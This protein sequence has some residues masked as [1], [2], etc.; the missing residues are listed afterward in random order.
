MEK[1]GGEFLGRLSDWIF[2]EGFRCRKLIVSVTYIFNK[3]VYHNFCVIS[4]VQPDCS[5]SGHGSLLWPV[6]SIHLGNQVRN[7]LF[8]VEPDYSRY[9]PRFAVCKAPPPIP[10]TSYSCFTFF[11][12]SLKA[13]SSWIF[14]T[15]RCCH[16]AATARINILHE[17]ALL[18]RNVRAREK[19]RNWKRDGRKRETENWGNKIKWKIWK[20]TVSISTR[21]GKGKRLVYGN[22]EGRKSWREGIFIF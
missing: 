6:F 16:P 2:C 19:R 12:I 20:T 5:R 1:K 22:G 13:F 15:V 17:P 10:F 21:D 7:Y 18:R 11:F 4:H 14:M 3:R 9:I 8:F